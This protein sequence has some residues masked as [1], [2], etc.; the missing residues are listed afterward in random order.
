MFCYFEKFKRLQESNNYPS[1]ITTYTIST[2]IMYT[3]RLSHNNDY[4]NNL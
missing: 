1:V 4:K 3:S 2:L